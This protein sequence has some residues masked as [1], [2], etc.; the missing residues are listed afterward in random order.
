MMNKKKMMKKLKM[1]KMMET[2]VY[3]HI[4]AYINTTMPA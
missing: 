2:M 1:M 4:Y 3:K